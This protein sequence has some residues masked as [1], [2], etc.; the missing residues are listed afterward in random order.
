MTRPAREERLGC[1]SR[2]P[3]LL[4]GNTVDLP[5]CLLALFRLHFPLLR[6]GEYLLPSLSQGQVLRYKS[7]FLSLPAIFLDS[8]HH[9][10]H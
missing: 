3:N 5:A 9:P 10:N 2:P 4:R 1:F 6:H 8:P 7:A